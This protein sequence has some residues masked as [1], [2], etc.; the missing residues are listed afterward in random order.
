MR[1]L[2]INK[3]YR[4]S[5]GAERHLF[6]WES[7]LRSRGHDVK[8]FSMRH[9]ENRPCEQE[10]HFV[11]GVEFGMAMPWRNRM[12]AGLHAIWNAEARDRLD[13]LL[14]ETGRPDVAH[15]HSYMFHLTPSIF[16]PLRRLGVPVVQTCHDYAPVCVNQHLYDNRSGNICEACLHVGRLAPLWRRCMKGSFLWSAAGCAAGL[17]DRYLVGTRR[18]VSLFFAPSE[19]MRRKLVEGGLPAERIVHMPHFVDAESI[20]PADTPGE[21]IL[22]FGRL[23]PQKGL[24]TFLRAAA[25][26][27]DIPCAVLGGGD[28]EKAA[29]EWLR[30]RGIANVRLLGRLDG[31]ALWHA[32]RRARAVVVPSEWYEPFGLVVLEAMAAARAVIASRIGGPAE[33]VS[34]GETGLLF[35]AGEADALSQA[36]SALWHDPD[37]AIAMGRAGRERALQRYRPDAYY[38]RVMAHFEAL[39]R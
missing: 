11:E 16:L 31:E 24:F 6:D 22:F 13:G 2:L 33:I 9:P 30:D 4:L 20:V 27:P 8:V 15:L 21:F 23:V 25:M 3:F 7:L 39:V 5:G 14:R 12:A 37:L 17:V 18:I 19:F 36:M 1:I 32:V 38:S 29:G 28:L 10:K 35:A 34:H 26:R